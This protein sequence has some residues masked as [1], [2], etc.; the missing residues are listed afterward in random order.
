MLAQLAAYYASVS[1]VIAYR[2]ALPA[3]EPDWLEQQFSKIKQEGGEGW[4]GS[5]R[6]NVRRV[7]SLVVWKKKA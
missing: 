2:E 4:T 6:V 5:T 1:P 3:G 7:L